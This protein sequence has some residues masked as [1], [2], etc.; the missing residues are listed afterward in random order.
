[1]CIHIYICIY[2]CICIYIHICTYICNI[3]P[4]LKL[5][6]GPRLFLVTQGL[7]KV[8][9]GNLISP[10]K[11]QRLLLVPKSLP[12]LPLPIGTQG[13]KDCLY[14]PRNALHG[15]RWPYMALYG[16][17]SPLKEPFMIWGLGSQVDQAPGKS[18]VRRP[19]SLP[20]LFKGALERG[21]RYGDIDMEI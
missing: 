13:P 18:T 14:S 8:S 1:M 20:A 9:Q 16:P 21:C 2:I 3:Q 7:G 11:A 12:W 5:P 19:R 6:P 15:P 10:N 17:I 4:S